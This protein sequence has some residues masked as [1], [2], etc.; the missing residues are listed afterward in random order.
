MALVDN[1][2]SYWKLGD[3]ADS[4]GSNTLTNNGTV[5]FSAGKI[6]NAANFVAASSQYLSRAD[7]ASLSITG[8]M[9]LSMWVYISTQPS[10]TYYVLG[11]KYLGTGNQRSFEFRYGDVAGTKKF[12][13][14]NS[15]DG[16]GANTAIGT[17]DSSLATTTWTHVVC[18]YTA[19]AGT[20]QIYVN[21]S[22][23]GT[24]SSLKTNIFDSTALY[25]IGGNNNGDGDFLN[26][27]LDEYGIWSRTLSGAEITALY[28]SGAGNQY[29]FPTAYT[30]VG[31]TGAFTFTG[32]DAGLTRGYNISAALGQFTFTGTDAV[33]SLTQL[34]TPQTRNATLYTDLTRNTTSFSNQSRN[35]TSFS[36][37]S[38]NTTSYSD[39]SR[40]VTTFTPITRN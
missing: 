21:G 31:G 18:V 6:G 35:T 34:F 13:F 30:L 15:S 8:D 5:T 37:Q 11:S 4:V 10:G 16:T 9:T 3:T 28:N 19:S 25:G 12:E 20:A 23:V 24:I 36:A 40:N 39:Q 33:L 26:G 1:L 22:S 29:P 7:N 38:K 27:S 17:I 32:I 14:R 2:V